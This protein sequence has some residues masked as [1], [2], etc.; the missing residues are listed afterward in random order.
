MG[1]RDI[2]IRC[3]AEEYKAVQ[4]ITYIPKYEN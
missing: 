1:C 2:E 3:H 4:Y